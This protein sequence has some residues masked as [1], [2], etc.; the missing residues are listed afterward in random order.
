MNKRLAVGMAIVLL[1]AVGCTAE[2][3]DPGEKTGEVGQAVSSLC[4]A[5]EQTDPYAK[6]DQAA[7]NVIFK[8]ILTGD[9]SHIPT[10]TG[11]T[12]AHCTEAKDAVTSMHQYLTSG[13]AVLQNWGVGEDPYGCTPATVYAIYDNGC[14]IGTYG[15]VQGAM[16]AIA[17]Q[18]NT[19][20]TW[21]YSNYQYPGGFIYPDGSVINGA[22]VHPPKTT[23]N[24]KSVT[25]ALVDPGG[26][27]LTQG[28]AASPAGASAAG[29]DQVGNASRA[30]QWPSTCR[31]N[32]TGSGALPFVGGEASSSVAMTSGSTTS[33]GILVGA[34]GGCF[35]GQAKSL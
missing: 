10:G 34:T 20:Y 26:V 30:Y 9:T 17:D 23:V 3:T 25:G 11:T 8:A 24:G 1:G 19:C 33:H 28:L 32:T 21:T 14:P 16:Q 6:N 35:S 12:T 27:T 18:A 22:L 7:A 5:I 13:C 4:A 2:A 31:S 29:T 15:A